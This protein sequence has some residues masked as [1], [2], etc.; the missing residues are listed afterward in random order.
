MFKIL[1]KK[2]I[3]STNDWAKRESFTDT[4]F[5]ADE[6]TNGR[7]RINRKWNSPNNNNLYFS[8]KMRITNHIQAIHYN[9]LTSL[10]IAETIY[11]LYGFKV[12]IKWPNDILIED[13]KVSGILSEID[14]SKE[15]NVIIGVGINCFSD[16][17]FEYLSDIATFLDS[18]IENIDRDFFFKKIVETFEM[19]NEEYIQ[20]E[21]KHILDKWNNYAKIE[22]R[23]LFTTI[24]DKK[25]MVRVI[26]L[27][28]DG[29]LL[30]EDENG[31][32][33]NLIAGD[34]EYAKKSYN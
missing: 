27:N 31:G 26:K 8:I 23:M 34:V 12:V 19:L 7:G 21:F 14:S 11:S 13:K 28:N 6:Q 30:V 24:N 32:I 29:S 2:I 10:A 17:S 9:F 3:D 5:I 25:Q 18:Y 1:R 16:S 33:K 20:L 22:D 4:I 15:L